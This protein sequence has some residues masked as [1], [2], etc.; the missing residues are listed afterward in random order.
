MGTRRPEETETRPED[1]ETESNLNLSFL[2]VML[3]NQTPSLP[4][5]NHNEFIEAYLKTN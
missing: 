1:T 5:Y 2:E 4:N 3:I